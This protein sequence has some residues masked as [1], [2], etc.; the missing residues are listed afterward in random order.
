MDG[1]G[2]KGLRE[3][4]VVGLLGAWGKV[5]CTSQTDYDVRVGW[6]GW[7]MRTCECFLEKEKKGRGGGTYPLD[8]ARAFPGLCT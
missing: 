3:G 2:R 6:A 5:S 7:L 4:G 8:A 1:H